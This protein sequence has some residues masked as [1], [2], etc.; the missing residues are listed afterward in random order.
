MI[1]YSGSYSISESRLIEEVASKLHE[2]KQ[3]SL[4]SLD[5]SFLHQVGTNLF[6]VAISVGISNGPLKY[7][8]QLS[9]QEPG[10]SV[11]GG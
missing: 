7:L 5:V 4:V 11:L 3:S 2:E 1:N 6:Q 9:R 8:N 10:I